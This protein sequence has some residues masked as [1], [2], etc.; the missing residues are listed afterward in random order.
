M[1]LILDCNKKMKTVIL[2]GGLG[3]RLAEETELKPKP[4]VEIGGKPILWHIMKIY[5]SYGLNDFII[6][7]GYKGYLI[8]EY[9][10]NYFLHM[11]DITFDMQ[12]NSMKVNNSNTEPWT[13]TIVDTGQVTMTGGRLK[14]IKDYLEEDN[15]FC[16]TYGDGLSDININKL[17]EFHKKHGKKATLTAVRPAGRYG[18]LSV[19]EGQ[20][21]KRFKEKPE[22]DGNWI[23]GGF[24]VL[25]PSVIDL[26]DG[27]QTIWERDPLEKISEEGQLMAYKHAGFWQ[28]MDTLNE[29][30]I[31]NE[32]WLSG[33]AKWKVWE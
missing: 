5:S 1:N 17:V 27:D 23:S 14:R 9:F 32:Y 26:I 6:C 15:D 24:F 4:M 29:K 25:K 31:L 18:S 22:E 11:S 12:N 20:S 16:M 33:N 10:A 30:K 8:K 13:V 21:V 28:P 3:T 7:C 2:A 19:D